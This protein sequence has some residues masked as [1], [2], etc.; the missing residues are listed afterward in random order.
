[1]T[2]TSKHVDL[3]RALSFLFTALLFAMLLPVIATAQEKRPLL[4]TTYLTAV[5]PPGGKTGT[6]VRVRLAGENLEE[7]DRLHF[8]HPGI[9]AKP[10]LALPRLKPGQRPPALLEYDVTLSA[11]VP[12]GKYDVRTVGRFGVSNPRTFVVG[13]LDEAIHS[14]DLEAAKHR[15]RD[16]AALVN[17]GSTV[18]G[19]VPA[20]GA[21]YYRFQ[22]KRGDK[23]VINCS[24]AR[25]DSRIDATL[26]LYD[27]AGKQIAR[28]RDTEAYDPVMPLS[29]P[30]DGE[31]TLEIYDFLY[32]GGDDYFYRLSFNTAPYVESI[33]PP[34]AVP[35]TRGK[36]TVY[37]YHLP[38]GEPAA[39]NADAS[40]AAVLAPLQK[41]TV[42]LDIPNQDD[43]N[44]PRSFV[45]AASAMV[46]SYPLSLHSL[47]GNT[48]TV[49]F[50]RSRFPV[51]TEEE[52]NNAADQVQDI[53]VPGSVAGQFATAGDTDW[54]TFRA[55]ADETLW[56]DVLSSRALR[57]A[58]PTI[59]V[60]EVTYDESGNEKTRQIKNQDDMNVYVDRVPT[61]EFRHRD[62]SFAIKTKAGATYR[63]MIRD[64]YSPTRGDPR[65][66]YRLRIR[67]R[68]PD[69]RLVAHC[70]PYRRRTTG[71]I[72]M[73]S[74]VL[75]QGSAE[76]VNVHVFRE[77]GFDGDIRITTE[78]LPPGV[79]C[80]GAKLGG[81]ALMTSLVFNVSEGAKAAAV[82]IR[83]VGHGTIDG[84]PVTREAR[85]TA[86]I[87]ST[88]S[89]LQFPPLSRTTDGIWLSVIEGEQTP[90]TVAHDI[91]TVLESSL[92]SRLPV[93]FTLTRRGSF[94][95]DVEVVPEGLPRQ[96]KLDPKRVSGD[97]EMFDLTFRNRPIPAGTYTFYLRGTGQFEFVRHAAE[98]DAAKSELKK[99][100]QQIKALGEQLKVARSGEPP[101]S[102]AAKKDARDQQRYLATKLQIAE[103]SKE[104]TSRRL[105]KA[106]AASPSE[107]TQF[108]IMSKPIHIRIHP[109]PLKLQV[110]SGTQAVERGQ[111]FKLPV[112]IERRFGFGGPVTLKLAAKDGVSAEQ[113]LLSA[114]KTATE[115]VVRVDE[116][117]AAGDYECEVQAQVRHGNLNLT[118]RSSFTLSVVAPEAEKS[119]TVAG[120]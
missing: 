99:L 79:T 100:E 38:G 94:K 64:V 103:K 74:L 11:D 7:V 56:I 78:G 87:N 89:P 1:M 9:T 17:M 6:T 98:I 20:S 24:A 33:F 86:L 21:D 26:V 8:S 75:R 83:I 40:S 88:E 43:T 118:E 117:A 45:A 47:L 109:T 108:G 72:H 3:Q 29:I 14:L 35:G 22:A 49:M 37:G 102:E 50:G 77:A 106:Q 73:A 63:I 51:Q 110:E 41:A 62:P 31:Y 57:N 25:I 70:D 42:Q 95:G 112:N 96:L 53:T 90:A 19:R 34:A 113:V 97:K 69:F 82:P 104:K 67:R 12:E 119:A 18:N 115:L 52:P 54:Y 84:K 44:A 30:A 101:A 55:T 107:K 28:V 48:N 2:F 61:Y 91:D 85:T 116:N 80:E 93:P 105:E 81:G 71:K 68:D 111:E 4:P 58:D 5:F 76:A 15:S 65:M 13:R 32:R 59:R 92:G 16:A 120:K 46:D 23:I 27:A 60:L 39:E 114:D 66:S 10:A 36:F